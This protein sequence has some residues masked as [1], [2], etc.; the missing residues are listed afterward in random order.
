MELNNQQIR[1]LRGLAHHLKPVIM[2]GEKG[3][4]ENLLAELERALEDHELIK[5]TIAGAEREDRRA[6]TDELCEHSGAQ[7]VQIIGR[8]SVLY[9]AAKK[10]VLSLPK[11]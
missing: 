3:L 1:H 10:P 6:L 11:A 7:V 8:I 2:V 5:V 4:S 9:R